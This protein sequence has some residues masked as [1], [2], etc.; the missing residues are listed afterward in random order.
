MAVITLFSG[1]PYTRGYS[2]DLTSIQNREK[3][4]IGNQFCF[5]KEKKTRAHHYAKG[6]FKDYLEMCQQ[7]SAFNVRNPLSLTQRFHKGCY[8][9]QVRGF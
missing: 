9:K 8:E 1:F 4:G 3:R 5:I 2:M 6:S 7:C